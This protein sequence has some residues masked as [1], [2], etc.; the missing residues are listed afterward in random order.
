MLLRNRSV[1]EEFIEE[2]RKYIEINENGNKTFQNP[3]DTAKVVLRRKLIVIKA[4]LMKQEK[5]HTNKMK[6]H[7]KDSEEKKTVQNQQTKG[8]KYQKVNEQKNRKKSKRALFKKIKLRKI[9]P[10]S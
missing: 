5:C 9:Y 4:Q 2:A 6:Y 8:N 1:N 3:Y 10:E 7:L